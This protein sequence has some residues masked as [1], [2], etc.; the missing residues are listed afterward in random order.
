M[1]QRLVNCHLNAIILHLGDRETFGISAI[2]RIRRLD[3]CHA[4]RIAEEAIK[5]GLLHR[6]HNDYRLAL[7][8]KGQTMRSELNQQSGITG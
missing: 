3:F 5:R 4:A 8:A 6:P 7:T 1:P 2:Q